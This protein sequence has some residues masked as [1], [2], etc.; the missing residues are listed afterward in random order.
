MHSER[1]AS[2]WCPRLRK[3]MVHVSIRQSTT[4]ASSR[5]FSSLSELGKESRHHE[6][7][8]E[9]GECSPLGVNFP[10]KSDEKA[11]SYAWVCYIFL[12][13]LALCQIIFCKVDKK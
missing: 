1:I 11:G 12:R 6:G 3:K 13:L 4:L 8:S 10:L 7:E 5:A 2:A 9:T